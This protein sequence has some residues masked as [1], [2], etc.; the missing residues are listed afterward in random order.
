MGRCAVPAE[1]VSANW[2]FVRVL[3]RRTEPLLQAIVSEYVATAFAIAEDDWHVVGVEGFEADTA[4]VDNTEIVGEEVFA[5][6]K[7]R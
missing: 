5:R 6:R 7:R 3:G 1:R 2:T 4:C